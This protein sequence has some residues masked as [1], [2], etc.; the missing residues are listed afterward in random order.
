MKFWTA[1]GWLLSLKI[2][3]V[4]LRTVFQSEI[5]RLANFGSEP[6]TRSNPNWLAITCHQSGELS[7]RESDLGVE[8]WEHDIRVSIAKLANDFV[9]TFWNLR[10]DS[11][12][13]HRSTSHE[14]NYIEFCEIM[15]LFHALNCSD[16]NTLV[17]EFSK[18]RPNFVFI[19]VEE[20]KT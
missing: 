15:F 13:I 2:Q 10:M 1:A 16:W 11:R 7:V 20:F 18:F 8:N 17:R 12:D 6:G 19:L 5:V 4:Q 9:W 14:T 3:T